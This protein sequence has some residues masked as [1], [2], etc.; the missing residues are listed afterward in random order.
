MSV[1]LTLALL[2]AVYIGTYVSD[3]GR[4]RN[5]IDKYTGSLEPLGYAAGTWLV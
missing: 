2:G 5:E 1:V 4:L 3:E